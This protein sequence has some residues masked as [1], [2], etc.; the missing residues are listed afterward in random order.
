VK[1]KNDLTTKYTNITEF[2]F[3]CFVFFLIA[4]VSLTVYPGST[5]A[6]DRLRVATA[7][8]TS[9][10]V[11]YLL[12]AQREGYFKNEGLNVEIINMRGE[13][14]AKIAVAGEIDFFTQALSGLT[15]A[16]RGM[17][18]KILLIVD[19]KPSWDLMAQP[20]I[21]SF[22]QLK[23]GTIGILSFEGSVALATREMLRRNNLDP[24]K[25]V[26][27]LVMGGNDMRFM[28]LKGRAIQA[29][30]LDP[31]NSYR[32][33]KEGFNKLASAA[34]YITQYLSGG[35]CAPQENLRQAP[36]R[37]AR[38][39]IASLKGYLFFTTRRE[40]SINYMMEFLKS[41]D[42]D[43]VAAIYDSSV[44][45]VSR[46]GTAEEKVLEGIIEDIKRSTGVKKEFRPAEFFDF[47]FLRKAR[48]QLKASGWKP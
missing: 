4:A 10:S 25:D 2:F 1:P 38:F 31:A 6:V 47:S 14:A 45:V 18:L 30:L 41:K 13:L 8:M 35:I 9:P 5:H 22:A 32:A 34:E 7:S 11:L 20:H 23:G 3:A 42:R 21:K 33:Q 36:E 19:E 37:V 15:A 44:R 28:S 27:L 17:P 16:V 43:T 12:I 40:A 24:V 46:D 39:M 48:E 29:T 26:Q